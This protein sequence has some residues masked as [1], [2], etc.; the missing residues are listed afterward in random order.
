MLPAGG[1]Y[2]LSPLPARRRHH[3]CETPKLS[4]NRNP[5]RN[6]SGEQV[7][8]QREEELHSTLEACRTRV[9]HLEEAVAAGGEREEELR[10]V[11]RTA[12]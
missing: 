3:I 9:Q 8:L 1:T 5:E 6:E 11:V 2:R 7:L 10:K 4:V 12:R